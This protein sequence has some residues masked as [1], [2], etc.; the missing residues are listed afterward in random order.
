MSARW[1]MQMEQTRTRR[2][3]QPAPMNKKYRPVNWRLRLGAPLCLLVSAAWGFWLSQALIQLNAQQSLGVVFLAA[4]PLAF[5]GSTLLGFLFRR[6]TREWYTVVRALVALGAFA[7]GFAAGLIRSVVVEQLDLVQTFGG[8]NSL[9]WEFEWLFAILGV[10]AGT[11]HAWTRPLY[12]RLSQLTLWIAT[13]PQRA[14]ERITRAMPDFARG[15]LPRPQSS[16]RALARWFEDTRQR[17]TQRRLRRHRPRAQAL[18][19]LPARS[20][21]APP[22]QRKS[23]AGLRVLSHV[24]DRCPYCF[25]KVKRNDPRGVHICEVCG[26]PHHADCWAIA[27]K[28]QMPHLNV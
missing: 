10:F 21:Q 12:E 25:D 24:E 9:V 20:L 4:F 1:P 5:A 11:W 8:T 27:N 2:A 23:R 7:A 18:I 26:T 13:R 19:H 3:R 22:A 6:L 16:I 15:C 14:L 28:C 17:V